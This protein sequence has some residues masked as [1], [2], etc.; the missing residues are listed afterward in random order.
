MVK[1]K[2]RNIGVIHVLIVDDHTLF[3]K[4][5][6]KILEVCP[7]YS[8]H[9]DEAENRNAVLNSLERQKY[10]LIL[11]DIKMPGETGLSLLSIIRNECPDQRVLVLSMYPEKQYAIRSMENGASGYITK[12]CE[13]A[14]LFNAIKTIISGQR[15]FTPELTEMLAQRFLT[16]KSRSPNDSL[17][18]REFTI[19]RLLGSGYKSHEIAKRL[20]LSPKTIAT[21]KAKIIHKM[22]F[23]D[24][25][26]LVK[27]VSDN[28]LL[29]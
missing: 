23:T 22:G 11:L 8:I 9:A 28:D 25:T 27:Y 15:Y 17:S 10:E 21:H 26:D 13:P 2:E 18:E 16:G 29:D 4:G 1:N 5:L 24:N 6:K 7:D 3:R 19:L 20:Y 14:E 12:G